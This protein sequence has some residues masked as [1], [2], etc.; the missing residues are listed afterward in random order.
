[1]LKESGCRS[2]AR[3]PERSG[4]QVECKNQQAKRAY[5][6]IIPTNRKNTL[7]L[8]FALHPK[9]PFPERA[10]LGQLLTK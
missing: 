3:A 9:Q 7:T 2:R 8:I 1:M 5:F 10:A 4:V 6:Y